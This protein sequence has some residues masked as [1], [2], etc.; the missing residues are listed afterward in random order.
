LHGENRARARL[1]VSATGRA[2][3]VKALTHENQVEIASDLLWRDGPK[4]N[5]V[6]VL[7]GAG[8]SVAAGVPGE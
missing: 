2:R 1:K 6:L 4:E 7:T 8:V 3:R 5:R